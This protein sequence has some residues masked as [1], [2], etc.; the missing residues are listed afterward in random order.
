MAFDWV[1]L[2]VGVTGA[3]YVFTHARRLALRPRRG[4]ALR[5]SYPTYLL[6][7]VALA[8]IAL[9]AAIDLLSS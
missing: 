6:L 2:V 4:T 9:G 3:I 8:L 7:G 1:L 5:P